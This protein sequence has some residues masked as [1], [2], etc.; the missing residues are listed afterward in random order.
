MS[1]PKPLHYRG[2]YQ[3]QAKKVRDNAYADPTTRCWRCQQTLAQHRQPWHAGHLHDGQAG[4]PLAAECAQCNQS[5]GQ[6]RGTRLGQR[7]HSR[8]W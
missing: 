6:A 1:K 2:N 8:P 5:A 3:V 7:Q 4:S